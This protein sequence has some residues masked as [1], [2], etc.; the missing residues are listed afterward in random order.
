MNERILLVDDEPAV[1]ALLGRILQEKGY[2]CFTASSALE[3]RSRLETR[4][5]DLVLC[6]IRMPGETGMALVKF[7]RLALPETAVVMLTGVD[8]PETATEAFALGVYGYVTKPFVKNQ[9]LISIA[10]ALRRRNL[11][12]EAG[13]Y[14]QKL[15]KAVRERTAALMKNNETLKRKERELNL[16]A[17]ELEEMNTALNVLL[18]KRDK[19]R[20]ELQED[21][22]MNIKRAVEPCLKMLRESG[23]EK[24]QMECF[25]ILESSLRE[26]ISP[27][28]R[29]LSS[30]YFELTP[31]EI[32]VAQFVKQ[33]KRTKEIAQFLHLSENTV[34][35]HRFKIRRK[36][37]LINNK[38]NLNCYLQSIR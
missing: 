25:S 32:E 22:L 17:E 1:L 7:I 16:R 5:I 31:S 3:A 28:V 27:M 30:S 8:D 24:K 15:E 12:R 26:I 10:N 23:L 29:V 2:Q 21:L 18:K 19:D 33:G 20:L 11:E 4:E 6:D 9:M 14:R 36:L 38:V 13:L 37:G 34:L 35:S